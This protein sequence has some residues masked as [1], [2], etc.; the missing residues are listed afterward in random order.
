MQVIRTFDRMQRDFEKRI[1][2][3]E[4]REALDVVNRIERI[5]AGAA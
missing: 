5:C 4:L 3:G 1:G 2:S